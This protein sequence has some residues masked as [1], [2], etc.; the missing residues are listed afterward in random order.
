MKLTKITERYRRDFTGLYIC[1]GCGMEEKK[2]G[3]DDD[4]FHCN[5]MPKTKC[6]NCG[7]STEDL[8]LNSEKIK[9]KYNSYEII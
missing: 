2:N 9:T 4:N 5:V 3:Y 8:G 1:E 6:R 7:K